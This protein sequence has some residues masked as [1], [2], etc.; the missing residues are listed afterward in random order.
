M[1]EHSV[2]MDDVENSGDNGLRIVK[3]EVMRFELWIPLLKQFEILLAAFGGH[4]FALPIE[5]EMSVIADTCAYLE[6]ATVVQRQAERGQMLQAPGI[7]ALVVPE[8]EIAQGDGGVVGKNPLEKPGYQ[9]AHLV[10]RF[11]IR[12]LASLLELVLNTLDDGIKL[13]RDQKKVYLERTIRQIAE[14]AK[15]LARL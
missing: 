4:D 9:C 14:R 11:P 10:I 8:V 7:V 12:P 1:I 5:I 13:K 3:V 6:N 2:A 15:D